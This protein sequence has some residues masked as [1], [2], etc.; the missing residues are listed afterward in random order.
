MSAISSLCS[1]PPISADVVLLQELTR[2]L[3]QHLAP[4]LE[5]SGYTLLRQAAAAP[6]WVGVAVKTK[7]AHLTVTH[8]GTKEFTHTRMGRGLVY[9]VL[10]RKAD[11]TSQ[12]LVLVCTAHLE[13][14]VGEDAKEES[15]R[16][17]ASQLREAQLF[18]RALRGKHPAIKH[19]VFGGDCNWDDALA[20]GSK[21]KLPDVNMAELARSQHQGVGL[22]W[23]DVYLEQVEKAGGG[24]TSRM[25]YTYDPKENPMLNSKSSLRRRFDRIFVDRSTGTGTEVTHVEVV[26]P[27]VIPGLTF[28][29]LN[30][31]TGTYGAEMP[32]TPSDH[33]PL[34]AR[35]NI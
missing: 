31:F 1:S 35:F 26:K 9:A 10:K 28:R 12:N 18:C 7:D 19:V 5:A 34:L 23:R 24:L 20:K 4:R 3:E 27:P 21:R 17:R 22:D 30:Q 13:S 11:F 8:T 29:R 32:V 2:D 15:A 25:G 33:F 16:C 6:Y 14:F